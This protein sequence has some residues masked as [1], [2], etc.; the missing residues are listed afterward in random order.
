M[1]SATEYREEDCEG[2]CLPSDQSA[3]NMP[4]FYCNDRCKCKSNQ[5]IHFSLYS[6]PRI[7][8]GF[9]EGEGGYSEFLFSLPRFAESEVS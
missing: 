3:A 6:F 4:H 1:G 8:K 5:Q 7:V 2:W 9:P